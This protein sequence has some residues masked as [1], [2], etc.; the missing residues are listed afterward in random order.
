L[1]KHSKI[2]QSFNF[3][4]IFESHLSNNFA[5]RKIIMK[6]SYTFTLLTLLSIFLISSQPA[7]ASLVPLEK[8]SLR[9]KKI[10]KRTKREALK[11]TLNY[12]K[13]Y[14]QRL[15]GNDSIT[16]SQNHGWEGFETMVISILIL[17]ILIAVAFIVL[18]FFFAL[19][20]LYIIGFCLLPWPIILGILLIA[21]AVM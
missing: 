6:H 8:T 19:P 12:K 5:Q 16:Q 4:F 21:V 18:G 10:K 7:Y 11:K 15:K 3:G 17:W 2:E 14:K 20:F 1:N 13:K 9:T